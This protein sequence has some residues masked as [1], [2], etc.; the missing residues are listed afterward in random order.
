MPNA[1]EDIDF[2]FDINFDIGVNQPCFCHVFK[3]CVI[4]AERN[5]PSVIEQPK[6]D[7]L[8]VIPKLLNDLNLANCKVDVISI[9]ALN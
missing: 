8:K 3:A 1:L 4:V 7:I 2:N 9:L 6:F 5:Y